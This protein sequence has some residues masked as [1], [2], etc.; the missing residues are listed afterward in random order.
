MSNVTLILVNGTTINCVQAHWRT[1]QL[2][3]RSG[4]E[5]VVWQKYHWDQNLDAGYILIDLNSGLVLN[6]QDAFA[7]QLPA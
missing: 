4:F 3:I 1:I 2:L 6:E 5:G 7:L